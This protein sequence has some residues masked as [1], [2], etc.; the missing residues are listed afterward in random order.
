MDRQTGRPDQHTGTRSVSAL[1]MASTLKRETDNIEMLTDR[2]QE[3]ETSAEFA[4]SRVAELER[5]RDD[6]EEHPARQ[7]RVPAGLRLTG[8]TEHPGPL[9]CC[10]RPCDPGSA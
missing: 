1:L 9:T 4:W 7:G 3:A 5:P 8:D 6:A 2:L 10:C